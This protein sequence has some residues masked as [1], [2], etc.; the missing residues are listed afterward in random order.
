MV[1]W[2]I[3]CVSL[4]FCVS[5]FSQYLHVYSNMTESH[6]SMYFDVVH[7]VVVRSLDTLFF[8]PTRMFNICYIC[9]IFVYMYV[10]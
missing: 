4:Y 9:F 6:C 7:A 3:V 2:N 8:N 10:I 5:V 1:I